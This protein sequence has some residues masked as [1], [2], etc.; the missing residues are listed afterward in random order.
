MNEQDCLDLL[1]QP[2]HVYL[3]QKLRNWLLNMIYRGDSQQGPAAA[4][5]S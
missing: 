4:P 2:I 1:H 3:E 5:A